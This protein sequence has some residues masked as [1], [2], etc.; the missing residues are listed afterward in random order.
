MLRVVYI[1]VPGRRRSSPLVAD[2]VPGC[3]TRLQDDHHY[4]RQQGITVTD[5]GS[6]LMFEPVAD[7]R[8]KALR[9]MFTLTAKV[10]E[11]V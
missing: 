10:P 2:P 7:P 5:G 1:Y 9:A 11:H 3:G 4:G 8:Q 6:P